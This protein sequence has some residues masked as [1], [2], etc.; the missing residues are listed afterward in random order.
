MYTRVAIMIEKPGLIGPEWDGLLLDWLYVKVVDDRLELSCWGVAQHKEF[1][2]GR[3]AVKVERARCG[4][5][6]CGDLISQPGE[7]GC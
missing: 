4:L 6:H 5:G 1:L 7:S 3:D 2:H